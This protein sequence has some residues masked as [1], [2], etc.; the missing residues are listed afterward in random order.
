MKNA[1]A[2]IFNSERLERWNTSDYCGE[3]DQSFTT[4]ASSQSDK[5]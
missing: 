5:D 4:G 3:K 2:S 1:D